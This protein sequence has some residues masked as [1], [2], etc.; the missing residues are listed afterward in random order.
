MLRPFLLYKI[1]IFVTFAKTRTKIDVSIEYHN[2][3]KYIL[4][5]ITYYDK[6]NNN[7]NNNNINKTN[8]ESFRRT[9]HVDESIH[10][11]CKPG[12]TNR[13]KCIT[14]QHNTAEDI[15]GRKDT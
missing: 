13:Y 9:K 15:K 7:N 11:S 1:Y 14:D 12:T 2:N 3:V 10:M 5:L 6:N 4:H 8:L